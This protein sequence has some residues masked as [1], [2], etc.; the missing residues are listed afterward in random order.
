VVRL[1]VNRN[2]VEA[3]STDSHGQTPLSFA[4]RG[5]HKAVVNLLVSR[6]DIAANS[7][8]NDGQT[9]LFWAARE[10]YEAVV[11]LLARSGRCRRGMER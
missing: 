1:L 10:G 2:D 4:A 9:P 7:K 6:D 5:G 8:D 3:N 11:R